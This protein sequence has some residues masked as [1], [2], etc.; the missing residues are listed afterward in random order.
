MKNLK[1]NHNNKGFTLI[2][3]M[4]VIA[5]IGIL[6]AI[7]IPQFAA[8][9]MRAFNASAK[10]TAHNA[11]G[12]QADLRSELG[13]YGHSSAA[14]V[15]LNAVDGGYAIADTVATPAMAIGATGLAGTGGRIAG[16]NATTGKVFGISFGYG[17]NM[18]SSIEDS[19]TAPGTSLSYVAVARSFQGDTQYGVDGDVTNQIYSC[20]NSSLFP[21]LVLA[22]G[23]F[24]AVAGAGN[25]ENAN[26]F[27]P[28]GVPGSGDEA[29]CATGLPDAF[30]RPVQ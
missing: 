11:V 25:T 3:L 23:D 28:N 12:S 5:I 10:A 27:D 8:Y 21:N 6:A 24:A 15:L 9:R 16:T 4:I 1:I 2:E 18:V 29:A 20:S 19:S 30:W 14:P 22:A 7:A 26:D 13:S 17:A